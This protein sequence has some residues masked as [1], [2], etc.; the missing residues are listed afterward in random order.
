MYSV[1]K[2]PGHPLW[3]IKMEVLVPVYKYANSRKKWDML[4]KHLVKAERTLE[5]MGYDHGDA[6]NGNIMYDP[7]KDVCKLI[8]FGFVEKY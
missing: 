7:K 4:E 6:H 8:D 2:I 5:K 1:D 3:A